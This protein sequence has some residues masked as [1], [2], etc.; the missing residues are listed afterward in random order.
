MTDQSNF[1]INWESI[2]RNP[3]R[4]MEA[5]KEALNLKIKNVTD[6][7]LKNDLLAQLKELDKKIEKLKLMMNI[8]DAGRSSVEDEDKTQQRIKEEIRD[9]AQEDKKSS[10]AN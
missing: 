4:K 1:D 9:N 8:G 5:E 10:E 6:L 3:M 7:T 2:E